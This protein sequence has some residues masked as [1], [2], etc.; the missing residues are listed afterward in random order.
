M[1]FVV[2]CE[3]AAHGCWRVLELRVDETHG[4]TYYRSLGSHGSYEAAERVRKALEVAE[5]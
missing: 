3:N 4:R 1:R 2:Y 5:P